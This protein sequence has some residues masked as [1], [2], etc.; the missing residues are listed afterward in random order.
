MEYLPSP[1]S[2]R[3]LPWLLAVISAST[4]AASAT[5]LTN[6]S[7]QIISGAGGA[8][9]AAATSCMILSDGS[10]WSGG[11]VG[12]QGG[13]S[14]NNLGGHTLPANATFK[15]N[16]GATVDSFNAAYG[17][18]NWTV[19]N[20]RLT[21][22]YTLY[23]NNS[24]FNAG[25]GA[26]AIYWVGDDNWVQGTNNPAYA[27]NRAT[28]AA[29]ATNAARL[30]S[31]D[32]DWTTPGYQGTTNDLGKSI[33]VTDKIGNRQATNSYALALDADFVNDITGASATNNASVS[34]Y[35][36]AG[37]DTLGLTIF[38]G[39]ANFLPT[40]SFDVLPVPKGVTVAVASRT[41]C[42]TL[43]DGTSVAADVAG[44]QGAG[45]F[46][47]LG[48]HFLAGNAALK[49][50][51]GATVD[52]LNA[53]YGSG[54]WTVA[55]ARLSF[56]YS[57]YADDSYY[58]SG[59]GTFGVYWM[60]ND[61]W[62]PEPINAPVFATNAA[63]LKTWAGDAA[64]LAA[65]TYDWTTPHYAGTLDDLG[66]TAWV[67]DATGARQATNSYPLSLANQFV[68]DLTGASAASNAMVSLY[69][70]AVSDTV[71]LTLFTGGGTYPPTLSFDVVPAGM[72]SAPAIV[73]EPAG[74]T[75]DSGGKAVFNVS[76]SGTQPLAYQW[77]FNGSAVPAA[78]A[79]NLAMDPASPT[80][81]GAY[82]VVITNHFGSVTSDVAVLTVVPLIPTITSQPASVTRVAGASATFA[83]TAA[84]VGSLSYQWYFGGDAV[85]NATATNLTIDAVS[86]TQA[87][88]YTVVITNLYG[89]VTSGVARLTIVTPPVLAGKPANQ[90]LTSGNTVALAANATG[91]GPIHY[92]W[93]KDG[94]RLGSATNSALDIT[95]AGVADSGTYYVVCTNIQ[96]MAISRPALVAVDN[97]GV[98][99]WG[100]NGYYGQLGDGTTNHNR[101]LPEALTPGIV[102]A[103]VGQESSYYLSNNGTLWAIGAN[104][105]GQLGTGNYFGT[106][107]PVAVASNVVAV[108]AGQ[109]HLLFVTADGVL[110][111]SGL[112]YF[113]QLGAPV[114]NINV[115]LQPSPMAV[116]SNV[117][118]VAAGADHS[119]YLTGDGVLWTMGFNF[120]GQLGNGTKLS[121]STPEAAASNVVAIAAGGFHSMFIQGDGTL[122]TMGCNFYGQLGD[123]TT[124]H[125]AW[126]MRVATNVA[127]MAGGYCHS[128][129]VQ[130][131][132]TLWTMGF[133]N[134]GQL[135]NGATNE[136]GL[137]AIVATNVLAPAAG[138]YHSLFLKYDGTLW[139]MGYNAYGQLGNGTTNTSLTPVRL[140][141]MSLAGIVS[142]TYANYSLA[143]GAPAAPAIAAADRRHDGALTMGFS[144]LPGGT[145][146]IEATTNPASAWQPISTN[147]ADND[148]T[149]TFTDTNTS[150]H[151]QQFYR[152][153]KP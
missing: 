7:F 143:V 35:L 28:L 55:N 56:Q 77:Y 72:G 88:T 123:G 65:A 100:Y 57:L 68:S 103:A 151:S 148:G 45:A 89:S 129:V 60:A 42:M 34:L 71:G 124:N 48:G 80:Q 140:P 20:P 81:A 14:V 92:Q 108:A 40:L 90:Q 12:V 6:A 51:V 101:F 126:P 4:V 106:H 104:S 37:S 131:D 138:Y 142:G 82:T 96:G 43:S 114:T 105:D 41:N 2:R 64:L 134:R 38:T 153:H 132:G 29:W 127:A 136:I 78:V 22:Q 54:T 84:G 95:N 74:I 1:W 17:A 144:G 107:V 5:V 9:E 46:N 13:N 128:L 121:T 86:L 59:A 120:Y 102:A 32:Y 70:M 112:S 116:A 25:P 21:F 3:K 30:G 36:M 50:D 91:L 122:W 135:G 150:A 8:G 15:Y 19:A 75:V 26:F 113:G 61:G 79:A 24:R 147:V 115:P 119:L 117:V 149:W 47:N 146:W 63:A 125:A 93:F 33:W 58:N 44:V 109:Y 16:I 23:A 139:L 110:W 118:A 98:L 52:A 31:E 73:A 76:A 39:G 18:G 111:A 49:F 141:G 87:G 66:T 97:P 11:A 152:I 69:L 53:T 10:S 83:V 94:R 99:G 67:T 133:G 145:Y 62:T 85:T 137:P 27:T 130:A